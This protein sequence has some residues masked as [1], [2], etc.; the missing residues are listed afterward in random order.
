MRNRE[1]V[2]RESGRFEAVLD[3]RRGLRSLL[4][5]RDLNRMAY[6]RKL[7][8]QSLINLVYTSSLVY[9][10][11]VRDVSRNLKK[12]QRDFP[13]THLLEPKRDG[14]HLAYLAG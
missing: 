11:E 12:L 7:T 13:N 4:F 10:D 5:R 2:W 1:C 9:P 8:S 6:P 3:F 14:F